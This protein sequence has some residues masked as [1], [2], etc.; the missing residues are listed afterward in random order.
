MSKK[1]KLTV[2]TSLVD[3]DEESV[4]TPDMMRRSDQVNF[5]SP[6]NS[7]T[8]IKHRESTFK[9]IDLEDLRRGIYK[10]KKLEEEKTNETSSCLQLG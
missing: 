10:K 4:K 8:S 5:P 7:P 2:S 1:L 6:L 9:I 3:I